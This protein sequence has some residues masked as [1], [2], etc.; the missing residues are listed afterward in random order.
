LDHPNVVPLYGFVNID[1]K[2]CSVRLVRPYFIFALHVDIQV[3]PWM[4]KGNASTFLARFPS[5]DRMRLL[6]ETACGRRLASSERIS[7]GS[8]L[9]LGLEYLHKKKI[10]HGDVRA[11][12][13]RKWTSRNG[14]PLDVVKSI[15]F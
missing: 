13:L 1:G 4:D 10:V 14:R 12:S 2:L 6:Y 3:T 11:V 8:M 15:M 9:F 5:V 7:L